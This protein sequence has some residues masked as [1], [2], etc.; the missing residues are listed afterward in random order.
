MLYVVTEDANSAR[1]FWSVVVK[2]FRNPSDYTIMKLEDMEGNICAGNTTLEKQVSKAFTY[3]QTGDSL[4]VAFDNIGQTNSF[5]P[6]DFL[7]KVSSRCMKKGIKFIYTTYYFTEN[8]LAQAFII[9]F[10]EAGV[11]REHFANKLLIE[12]TSGIP[13][14]FSLKETLKLTEF[15]DL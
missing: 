9:R 10:P 1:D 7:K 12:A 5:N 15:K 8:S 11:N 2:T 4:F 6:K 14:Y 13:G 3:M